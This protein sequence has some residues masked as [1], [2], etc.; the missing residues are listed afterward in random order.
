MIDDLRKVQKQYF[1][2]ENVNECL[3]QRIGQLK[4]Q[5]DLS[6]LL[7]GSGKEAE[8]K[9]IQIQSNSN[10]LKL[11]NLLNNTELSWEDRLVLKMRELDL[12][13]QQVSD[14]SINTRVQVNMQE[15]RD[16]NRQIVELTQTREH[17]ESK[18]LQEVKEDELTELQAEHNELI[19]TYEE[20]IKRK[21]DI[22]AE[23][24]ENL[25]LIT[26]GNSRFI[27]G[28]EIL[29]NKRLDIEIWERDIYQKKRVSLDI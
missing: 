7:T 21:I 25:K 16:K 8:L 13:M 28:E 24:I 12:A 11:V 26:E 17:I 10:K 1:E 20:I 23:M 9:T 5:R 29:A 27:Q 4:G 19:S 14:E 6:L 15:I 3:E 2:M 18:M 22:F